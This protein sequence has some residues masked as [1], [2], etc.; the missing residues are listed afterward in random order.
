MN[1]PSLT[2]RLSQ[3]L[4]KGGDTERY[5]KPFYVHVEHHMHFA[6]SVKR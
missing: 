4:G 6:L 2:A 1:L 3:S 5:L